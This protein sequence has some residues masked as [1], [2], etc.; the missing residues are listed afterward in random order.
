[1]E[2]HEVLASIVLGNTFAN[3]AMIGS[4][5]WLLLKGGGPVILPIAGLFIFILLACEVLPKA[6]GVRAPQFWSILLARP[7]AL[8][9]KYSRPARRLADPLEPLV[10]LLDP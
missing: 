2:P 8:L 5:L 1:K 10:C 6:F 9:T 3:A 4:V 7:V